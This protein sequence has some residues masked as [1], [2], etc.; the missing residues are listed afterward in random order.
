MYVY[1]I[2]PL[3]LTTKNILNVLEN[4]ALSFEGYQGQLLSISPDLNT[5]YVFTVGDISGIPLLRA[6]ANAN[7]T[8]NEFGGNFGIGTTNP[9]YKLE[10]GGQTAITGSTAST[11]TTSGALIV[12]G[13]VGIGGS[14]NVGALSKFSNVITSSSTTCKL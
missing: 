13:G 12:T 9:G 2:H 5:G 6:N 10:I 4:N 8:A 11:S 7:V 3:F 14:L 1:H